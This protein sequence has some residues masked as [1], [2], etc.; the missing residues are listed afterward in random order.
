MMKIFLNL[1]I[2]LAC[3]IFVPAYSQNTTIVPDSIWETPKRVILFAKEQAVI[4][5]NKIIEI[6]ENDNRFQNFSVE[7]KVNFYDQTQLGFSNNQD[8]DNAIK[9]ELKSI[10]LAKENNR[11]DLN[12][13]GSRN[14]FVYHNYYWVACYEA[15]KENLDSAVHYSLLNLSEIYKYY[16]LKS[17]EFLCALLSPTI[18]CKTKQIV[19][20]LDFGDPQQDY[21]DSIKPI[22]I[23]GNFDDYHEAILT[24]NKALNR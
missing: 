11:E 17:K 12:F 3:F 16:G 1:F 10:Q 18:F 4:G 8:W 7:A 20:S 24:I 6:I 19:E 15:Y 21:N 14:P 5:N 2:F 13:N 23:V 9:Y 22:F